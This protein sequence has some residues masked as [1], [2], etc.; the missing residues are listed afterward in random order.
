MNLLLDPFF[1]FDCQTTG[2]NPASGN[3][4]EIAWCHA[5][6]TDQTPGQVRSCLVK[7]TPNKEI[8]YRIQT[9]TGITKK[10]MESAL[11][12]QRVYRTVKDALSQCKSNQAIVHYASFERPF[13]MELFMRH[14]KE[15]FPLNLVCTY[16]IAKRIFPNLPTKGIRGLG[17][18]FGAPNCA[19]K[20]S[21]HHVELTWLI[22]K[23]LVSALAEQGITTDDD[24]RNWLTMP[25]TTK[26]TKYEYPLFQRTPTHCYN[27]QSYLAQNES[28]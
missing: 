9:L 2:A 15:D 19:V 27:W 16:Q 13:L 5:S 10:D 21:T 25:V 22:W 8:P 3:L 11:S 24:L 28:Q 17:G 6:A 7:Q 18:F 20:R 1:F 26:R 4:L 12:I 14:G 23:G